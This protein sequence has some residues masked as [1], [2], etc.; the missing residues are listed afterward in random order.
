MSDLKEFIVY[1]LKSPILW[2]VA[3][4][5]IAANLKWLVPSAPVDVI[6]SAVDLLQVIGVIV[7][8][9]L[10]GKDVGTRRANRFMESVRLNQLNAGGKQVPHG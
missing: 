10:G 5:W 7:V 2:A 8:A 3:I 1:A 9:Y 4:T 6:N